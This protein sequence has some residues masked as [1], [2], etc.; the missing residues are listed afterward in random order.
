MASEARDSREHQRI[1]PGQLRGHD[2]GGW[3]EGGAKHAAGSDPGRAKDLEPGRISERPSPG[4]DPGSGVCPVNRYPPALDLISFLITNYHMICVSCEGFRAGL[5][6]PRV[7]GQGRGVAGARTPGLG[8][9][10]AGRVDQL[11]QSAR[12]FAESGKTARSPRRS[13]SSDGSHRSTDAAGRVG[14]RRGCLAAPSPP[15]PSEP[16]VQVSEYTALQ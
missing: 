15:P 11:P 10:G 7:P 4:R 5:Q 9:Q 2:W 13:P 8:D 1:T 6:S 3:V 14:G 16:C 12:S